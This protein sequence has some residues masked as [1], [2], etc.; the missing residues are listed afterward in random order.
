M[1]KQAMKLAARFSWCKN[2]GNL[3]GD[4]ENP[5]PFTESF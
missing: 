1:G 2:Q 3:M 5:G 4:Y